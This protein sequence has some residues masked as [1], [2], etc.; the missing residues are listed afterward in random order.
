MLTSRETHSPVITLASRVETLNPEPMGAV[1]SLGAGGGDLTTSGGEFL[2][3]VE[4]AERDASEAAIR[5]SEA[6]KEAEAAKGERAELEKELELKKHELSD[7]DAQFTKLE[8]LITELIKLRKDRNS[9]AVE[10]ARTTMTR[11]LSTVSGGGSAVDTKKKKGSSVSGAMCRWL[12]PALIGGVIA[13][14]IE[15]FAV[16]VITSYYASMQRSM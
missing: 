5:A 12:I 6:E 4:A 14:M 2:S 9:E 15:T 1:C 11:L 3:S 8:A 10:P 7:A 16:R 13:V